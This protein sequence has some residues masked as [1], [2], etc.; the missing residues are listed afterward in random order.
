VFVPEGIGAVAYLSRNIAI[1]KEKTIAGFMVTCVGDDR[2]YSYLPS[3]DGATLSDQIA[4]HVLHHIDP[5]FRHYTW[6]DRGSDEQHYC[7]PGVDLPV[8]TIMRSKYGVYPEYH[9]SLDTL[10]GVVTP[11]GLIGGFQALREAILLLENNVVPE[12]TT[13]C[14]PQLGR[15]GLYPSLSTKDSSDQVR[16]M[17][18]LLSYCDGTHSLLEIAEIIGQPFSRLR[19]MIERFTH[20]GLVAVRPA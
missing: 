15:R 3:R 10:G 1:M 9:T 19:G 14:V 17:L 4:R 16:V 11:T 12:V 13:L 5:T 6:L 20:E 18:D 2:T 8:A 7:S